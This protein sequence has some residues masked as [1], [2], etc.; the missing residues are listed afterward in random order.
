MV[1][2]N[3]F[4]YIHSMDKNIKLNNIEIFKAIGTFNCA[5]F[6]TKVFKSGIY[7]IYNLIKWLSYPI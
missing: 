7:A 1:W 2:I 4:W 3:A 6:G 5:L